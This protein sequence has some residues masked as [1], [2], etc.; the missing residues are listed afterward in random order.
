VSCV[1]PCHLSELR[2]FFFSS[3]P[4]GV[5]PCSD[6]GG[7]GDKPQPGIY[8]FSGLSG[9]PSIPTS[10]FLN[11]PLAR[12]WFLSL[13]AHPTGYRREAPN[14]NRQSP[15]PR[16]HNHLCNSFFSSVE[17]SFVP[18]SQNT[19]PYFT[20][21]ERALEKGRRIQVS[22][23]RWIGSLSRLRSC[24]FTLSFSNS[25]LSPPFPPPLF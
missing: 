16:P 10:P 15:T 6:F 7:W 11:V 3:F 25:L 1:S 5:S 21:A 23:F 22:T 20:S 12:I 17:T 14:R 9:F 4:P 18:P 2:I 13:Q 8:F 24:L 19:S